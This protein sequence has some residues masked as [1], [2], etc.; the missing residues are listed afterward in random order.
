MEQNEPIE[1]EGQIVPSANPVDGALTAVD[2]KA[3]VQ[4]IQEVMHGVMQA[5]QHYGVIPGTSGKPTLL[6]AGAEK[7]NTLFR[8][9]PS[10][11]INRLDL[12]G[13]HREYEV[14]CTMTHFPTGR[15][16]GQGV[17]TCS[18]MESKYRWR[19]AEIVCPHCGK[20][21]VI[22]GKKEYGGGWLCWAKRGG[23]GTKFP[24]GDQAIEGQSTE[25]VE[26]PDIADAWNTCLKMG[27]KRAHIDAVLTCTSASD[28]FTQDLEDMAD[29]DRKAPEQPQTPPEAVQPSRP[30]TPTQESE[31]AQTPPEADSS[32]SGGKLRIKRVYVKDGE[33]G[34]R[35]WTRFDVL[36]DDDRRAS[37][38]DT[39]L[40][41]IAQDL[42]GT[43]T[44]VHPTV[45]EEGE[46]WTLTGLSAE[47]RDAPMTVN[48]EDGLEA[49]KAI[50]WA[51]DERKMATDYQKWLSK[52]QLKVIND[53]RPKG[54]KLRTLR[55]ATP[56]ELKQFFTEI[57]LGK[58]DLQHI[59]RGEEAVDG[60]GQDDEPTHKTLTTQDI[61]F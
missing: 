32:P 20:A 39:T 46:F 10:F 17:G 14:I 34:G 36:F 11:G 61:P 33:T 50:K 22:R 13:G 52:E 26:N 56:E 37:T 49:A 24:D 42:E 16:W 23:C 3:Q 25:R 54:E 40:G 4:L 35:A 15:I 19:R 31:A 48:W 60:M 8:L 58:H 9:A 5:D 43:D 55:A 47:G 7:L 2:I 53:S 29:H 28:I 30:E 51:M 44:I 45:K 6:K 41:Q 59:D 21:A 27:K 1:V 38:F 12:P 18:T 57:S